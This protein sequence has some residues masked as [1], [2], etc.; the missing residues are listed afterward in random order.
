MWGKPVRRETKE[1]SVTVVDDICVKPSERFVKLGPNG[2][3]L[4]GVVSLTV[5][6]KSKGVQSGS[7]RN[8]YS[9]KSQFMGD[10]EGYLW[11][12]EGKLLRVQLLRTSGSELLNEEGRSAQP[13][14]EKRSLG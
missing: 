9:Q 7:K 5:Q 1:I 2:K 10:A 4:V 11:K 6:G 8:V 14:D 13:D 3:L 12:R